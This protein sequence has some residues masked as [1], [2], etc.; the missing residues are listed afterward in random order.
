MFPDRLLD[1]VFTSFPFG[2]SSNG[3]PGNGTFPST[4]S[5]ILEFSDENLETLATI[6]SIT[7]SGIPGAA[8]PEQST[9]VLMLL[10]FAGLGFVGYRQAGR[11]P[12]SAA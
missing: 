10:G 12:A 6:G 8:V 2:D 1:V 11:A 9:W 4:G 7:I 3:V 5:S